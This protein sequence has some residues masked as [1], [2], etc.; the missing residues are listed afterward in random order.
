MLN[1]H[2]Y[3]PDLPVFFQAN[4]S[5]F[6]PTLLIGRRPRSETFRSFSRHLEKVTGNGESRGGKPT[7]SNAIYAAVFTV[8]RV[9][10]LSIL[11]RASLVRKYACLQR[12]RLIF[13]ISFILSSRASTNRRES[14]FKLEKM[15]K[16]IRGNFS[17][18]I[19]L[20]DGRAE[21]TTTTINGNSVKTGTLPSRSRV[22]VL[23]GRIEWRDVVAWRA[24]S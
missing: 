15:R 20:F 13:T 24:E 12:N 16:K 8:P 4:A 19:F 22:V 5:I 21:T 10:F 14:K 7:I 18:G 1:A 17:L 2:R 23:G 11:E 6:L 3:R 9:P